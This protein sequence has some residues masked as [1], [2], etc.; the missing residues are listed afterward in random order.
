MTV[1]LVKYAGSISHYTGLFHKFRHMKAASCRNRF[2]KHFITRKFG[3]TRW[4]NL[5]RHGA[6]SW[7]FAGSNPDCVIGLFH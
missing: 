5:L 1:I 2:Q 6:T 7:K 4:R 3:G